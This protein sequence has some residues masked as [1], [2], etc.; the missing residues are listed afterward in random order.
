ML[1]AV[2]GLAFY[3]AFIPHL[4]YLYP[5]H[6]D[7][8]VH[9]ARANAM[10]QSGS[11]SFPDPLL[12]GAQLSLSS[13][14]EAGYQLFLGVFQIISGISWMDLFRYFPGII[15]MIT[16][17]SVYVVARREGYGLEAAFLTCLIPTSVGVLGPAFLVPASLGLLCTPLILLL[18][19]NFRTVWSYLLIFFFTVFLLSVHAPSAIYPIILLGPYI[20]LNLKGNFRHSALVALS[21]VLPFLIIFPWIVDLVMSTARGLLTESALST[22]VQLPRVLQTYG[23]FPAVLALLGTFLLAIKGGKKNYGLILGLLGLLLML[24]SYYTFN[25]GVWIMYERGLT[26]MMLMMGIIGG[27]GLM[28]IRSFK[29]PE[30]FRARLGPPVISRYVGTAVSLAVVGIILFISIPVRL[31]APYYQM[32]DEQDYEAFTWIRDNIGDEYERAI[33]DPW[34]ATAFSAITNKPAYSRIHS[35]PKDKDK[36]AYAFIFEGS[37]DTALLR[38]NGISIIYTRVIEAN[39]NNAYTIN[40]PDLEKIAENVYLLKEAG[41]TE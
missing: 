31:D 24:V 18:A 11:I 21:L 33:L 23:Y 9:M 26:F 7:E 20:L 41:A 13:N 22:Y 36:E 39:G 16:V 30:G 14:L 12:G 32:I 1:L 3:I 34:K 35:Y 5:L 40:N 6:V 29:L 27:A 28:A 4:D 38:N 17:L 10:V 19:L 15:F 25:Y 37:S 8:W 2:L